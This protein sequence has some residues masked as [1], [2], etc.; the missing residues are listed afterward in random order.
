MKLTNSL[1]RALERDELVLYYQPQINIVTQDIVGFEALL[2]WNH[3]EYGMISPTVFIPLAEQTGLINPI[4]EWVLNTACRQNKKWQEMGFPLVHMS[5]NLSV[6]QF[7]NPNLISII[8][9]A[10][11]ESGLKSRYLEL[12]ITEGTAVKESGYILN[13]LQEL[14][15]LGISVA[16]DDFGTEYSSLSR[17][18]TLPADRIKIDMLF[19]HSI[20]QGSRDK[21]IAKSIIQMAQN[22]NL[23]VIAEGVETEEQFDFFSK[24]KCDEVQ[25]FYF[26][27]P[28]PAEEINKSIISKFNLSTTYPVH[29]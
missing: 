15:K 20:S 14:R 2:R 26:Y 7:R 29:P 3:P 9:N 10:L 21:A 8:K 23:K 19:V 6:E 25:G 5:V 11:S 13:E 16:I 27:K 1:Y 17:L 28:M 24:E 18:K 12:E 22:L 4:G